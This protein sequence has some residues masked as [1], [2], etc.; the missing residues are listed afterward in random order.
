SYTYLS[1]V[2]QPLAEKGYYVFPVSVIDHFLKENG[3]PTPAEMNSI[4]L[5]KIQ[6]HIGADAVLYVV[7]D[8]WGQ[9]YQVLSSVTVV[10]G[11]AKLI[12]VKTGELLWDAPIVA[13]QS[14]NN[15]NQGLIGALVSAAITQ[16]AGN[17]KDYTPAV[18]R[19]ANNAAINSVKRGLL[20]G[21][22][23][24]NAKK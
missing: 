17:V 20:D 1:T 8:N 12:S 19:L 13:Q 9:E 4:P 16:I 24:L 10:Q 22:Y 3:L 21:P 15:G 2:T 6:E 18:S 11:Y 23:K 14:S 5:D 7:I